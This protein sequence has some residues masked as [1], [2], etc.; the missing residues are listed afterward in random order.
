MEENKLI[1]KKTKI[2]CTMGPQEEDV[3]LL[4]KMMNAGMDVARFNFSHGTYEEQLRRMDAVRQARELVGKPVAMLLDTKGP[5]IRTGLLV[6]HQKVML[7]PG[8]Q[9]TLT[10]ED[11]DG[12][13]EKVSIT[14]KKLYEDVK[15]GDTILVDDGLIELRVSE[16][17]GEDIICDIINGGELSERKGCNIPGVKTQLP[18]IT[19]KDIEDIIWGIGQEFDVIA[20]SFIRNAEGVNQIKKLLADHGSTMPVFSKIECWEAVDNIDAIIEA[21]DGIMVA[22]GDL[23][24]EVPAHLVPHIQKEIISKCNKAYKPVITATQMLDSM[25]RNPRPTRAEVADVANAIYDGTDAVMLSGETAVGKYP[26]EA[27]TLMSE[28]ALNTEKY[29]NEAQFTSHRSMEQHST[30]SSSVC[31]AAVRTAKNVGASAL[32]IPTV[33]GKTARLM[34]NFRPSIP[35]Y[36]VS[37]NWSMV[38]RM[39]LYWG[40]IPFAG[41]KEKNQYILIDHSIQIVK[42]K[43]F[44][45]EGDMVVITAGDPIF[46]VQDASGSVSNMMMVVPVE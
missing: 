15:V 32:L 33:S 19:D 45:K 12:T 10:T 14:Y 20:A 23:G 16:I 40:V 7:E 44:L 42:D 21:S 4:C 38:R 2:I 31:Y 41:K 17:A 5:E 43:G 35:I 1:R 24:V 39:Q 8:K 34:S 11:I 9:I 18:A 28:I 29:M 46:D 3:E 6:D 26:V 37:P 30:V 27:V 22:R 13:A 25:I 36:A